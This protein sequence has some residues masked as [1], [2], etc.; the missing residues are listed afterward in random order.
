VKL[1]LKKYALPKNY[2]WVII[3]EKL[4]IYTENYY[5]KLLQIYNKKYWKKYLKIIAH[6]SRREG[7]RD[8]SC[9]T[10][11]IVKICTAEELRLGNY[12]REIITEVID[13]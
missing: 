6:Y 3:I 2:N 11:T 12:R 5:K 8:C 9:T 1:S 10:T 7:G 4:P 13:V